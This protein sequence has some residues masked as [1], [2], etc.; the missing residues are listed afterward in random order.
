MFA[1]KSIRHILNLW[2]VILMTVVLFQPPV[3]A[4]NRMP[5]DRWPFKHR[6]LIVDVKQ[7]EHVEAIKASLNTNA[8]SLNERRLVVFVMANERVH[9]CPDQH[10]P[11][12]SANDLATYANTDSVTLIGLDGGIKAQRQ[13]LD[14]EQLFAT[15]DAMPMRRAEMHRQFQ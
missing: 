6:I 7:D 1:T 14:F 11:N 12:V 3:I 4:K 10:A 15:I 5:I 8:A 9:V 13:D 2:F